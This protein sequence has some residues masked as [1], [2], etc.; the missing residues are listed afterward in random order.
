MQKSFFGQTLV[1]VDVVTAFLLRH[2]GAFLDKA[3]CV[4]KREVVIS[5][6]DR[7]GP[8]PLSRLLGVPLSP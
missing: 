6:T 4:D 3:R 1:W 8:F 5:D 7:G 2:F